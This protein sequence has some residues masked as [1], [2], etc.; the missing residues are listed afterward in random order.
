MCG[1]GCKSPLA[2]SEFCVGVLPKLSRIRSFFLRRLIVADTSNN[3]LN[4][5]MRMKEELLRRECRG[6]K[7]R[8]SCSRE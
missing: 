5:G 8:G 3:S 7:R 4:C 2:L 1:C 6:Q